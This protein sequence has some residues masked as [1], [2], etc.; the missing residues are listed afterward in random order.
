[1]F[2]NRPHQTDTSAWPG[3]GWTTTPLGSAVVQLQSKNA[4]IL[5][6]LW[7][8]GARSLDHIATVGHRRFLVDQMTRSLLHV[9]MG[10]AH[11]HETKAPRKRGHHSVGG[12]A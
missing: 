5:R 11:E 1:M 9:L 12:A 7:L 10:H 4:D 8:F 6:L 2:V 3:T